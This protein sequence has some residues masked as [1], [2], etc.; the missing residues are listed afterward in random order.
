V[1]PRLVAGN[2]TLAIAA[3]A[4]AI[5]QNVAAATAAS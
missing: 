4:R 3:I 5:A 1:M 2:P